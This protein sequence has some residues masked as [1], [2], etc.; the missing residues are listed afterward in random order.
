MENNEYNEKIMIQMI[1]QFS[2]SG[3]EWKKGKVDFF[4][5]GINLQTFGV[6][7]LLHTCYVIKS[8]NFFMD[9]VNFVF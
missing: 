8:D 1:T 4:N 6:I 2:L 5:L 3:G 7:W 9:F